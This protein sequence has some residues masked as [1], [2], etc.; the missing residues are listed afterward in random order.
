MMDIT[1]GQGA[2]LHL[3]QDA[4][5]EEVSTKQNL[6]GRVREMRDETRAAD[7]KLELDIPG[8][9][10]ESLQASRLVAVYRP[11]PVSKTEHKATEMRKMIG[12]APVLLKAAC[13][14]LID[15]CE[16]VMLRND[17]GKLVPIDDE[18][19]IGYDVRLAEALGF[20]GKVTTA[21]QV[22]V[23]VFPTEQAILAQSTEVTEWLQD[24]TRK[25]NEDLLGN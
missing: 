4:D 10:D 18:Q 21:R 25:S 9:Y 19:L 15:S 8:Y 5:A 14:T 1:P 24:V 23:E 13:D 12:R 17:E 20:G 22:V 3:A 7:H 6:L 16:Q 2:D 11:Y